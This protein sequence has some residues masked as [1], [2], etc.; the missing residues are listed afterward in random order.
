MCV[1]GNGDHAI[2]NAGRESI[3]KQDFSFQFQECLLSAKI[4]K[5]QKHQLVLLQ[6]YLE[7]FI[8]KCI[9]KVT[10]SDID[11]KQRGKSSF[12][13]VRSK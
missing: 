8:Y 6:E 4:K 1:H 11:E 7:T 9:S 12:S 13:I 3:I 5:K 2:S 10:K